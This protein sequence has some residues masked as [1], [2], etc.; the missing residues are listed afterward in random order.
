MKR[1][2]QGDTSWRRTIGAMALAFGLALSA[3]GCGSDRRPG[4]TSNAGAASTFDAA[5]FDEAVWQ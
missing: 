2:T 5:K 3:A 1:R 4:A